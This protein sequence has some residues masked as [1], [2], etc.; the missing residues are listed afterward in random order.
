MLLVSQ[1][2]SM[3]NWIRQSSV[4]RRR[5]CQSTA[6]T[7]IITASAVTE[8]RVQP[9]PS[10]AAEASRMA[11]IS[12]GERNGAAMA[13]PQAPM[14]AVRIRLRSQSW[15]RRT[16]S[17]HAAASTTMTGPNALARAARAMQRAV[18]A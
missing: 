12:D 2:K 4:R 15:R 6:Q 1:A 3:K 14:P 13:Q 8:P 5:N 18:P 10:L 11:R 9:S 16:K 7:K 17:R